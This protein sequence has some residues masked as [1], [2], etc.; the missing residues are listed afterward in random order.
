MS[1]MDDPQQPPPDFELASALAVIQAAHLPDS[2][3]REVLA[4]GLVEAVELTRDEL[5]DQA[6]FF[7]ISVA[8]EAARAEAE[9]PPFPKKGRRR[10]RRVVKPVKLPRFKNPLKSGVLAETGKPA[11]GHPPGRE[12]FL[13]L[14]VLARW[15]QVAWYE[16][17]TAWLDAHPEASP[18]RLGCPGETT[19]PAM[20]ALTASLRTTNGEQADHMPLLRL[21]FETA[22]RAGRTEFKPTPAKCRDAINALNPQRAEAEQ[23][24]V[25]FRQREASQS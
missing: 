25:G 2:L 18:A 15:V 19:D 8:C 4:R 13:P 24:A 9:R 16:A 21:L 6:A 1:L 10:K 14:D 5:A 17:A 22:E 23:M 3:D 7:M 20:P 12:R 11:R